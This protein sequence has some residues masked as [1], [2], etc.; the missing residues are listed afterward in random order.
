MLNKAG[1]NAF[2]DSGA[3]DEK[4][5]YVASYLYWELDLLPFWWVKTVSLQLKIQTIFST[6]AIDQYCRMYVQ[7]ISQW[8]YTESGSKS[9]RLER[10]HV[11]LWIL[12]LDNQIDQIAI[13]L[14]QA[15]SIEPTFLSVNYVSSSTVDQLVSELCI[16]IGNHV[17]QGQWIK[18]ISAYVVLIH[19][20]I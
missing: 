16:E 14:L 13:F 10:P 3:C 12:K 17:V 4:S 15:S 7:L 9:S 2:P 8:G 11:L 6:V 5:S 20:M 19:A 18:S 1:V